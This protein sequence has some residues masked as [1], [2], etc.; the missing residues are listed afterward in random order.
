MIECKIESQCFIIVNVYAPTKDKPLEQLLFLKNLQNLLDTYSGNAIIIGGDFNTY[1]NVSIDKKGGTS[2][3]QSEYSQ[4]LQGFCQEMSLTDIWRIRHENIPG[5]TRK[6][7]IKLGLVQSRLDL[8]LISVQLEYHVKCVK[9]A[10]GKSSDHSIISLELELMESHK[11]GKG[12]WKFNN[13]LL[14]DPIYVQ[15]IKDT[16][17][18][19][20]DNV[21]FENKNTLWDYVKCEIRSQTIIYS[22]KK[23]KQMR[24]QEIEL[25]NRL[26]LL[27]KNLS[28]NPDDNTY[29]NYLQ[30]KQEW[31]SLIKKKTE[32]II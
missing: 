16:I 18:N 11:R 15:L 25:S 32:A 28:N 24:K 23:A 22:T 13:D 3:R 12:L 9:I 17:G 27:E 10:L 2:E 21:N 7:K 5:F 6:Q 30:C 19:I 20:K 8:W 29:V 14:T 4:L 1:L 26:N 31:E